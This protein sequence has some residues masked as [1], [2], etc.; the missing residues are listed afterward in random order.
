MKKYTCIVVDDESLARQLL[1]V[2]LA[3]I[4]NLELVASCADAVEARFV[5]QQHQPD[6]LFLDIQM[7]DLTGFELLKMLTKRPATI[8]TT[9][10]SE[11]ALEGFELDVLDYLLKPIEFE[12]FFKAVSKA[13][14]WIDRGQTL[15]AQTLVPPTL[16]P[17]E[18]NQKADYFFVKSD[19]KIVKV[20]FADILYIEALQ[21]YVRIHT[22]TERIVT[23]ISMS[24]LDKMLETDQFYRIHRSFI[25]NL[26][27][28]EHIEGHQVRI[29]KANLPVSKGQWEA[30]L[31]KIRKKGLGW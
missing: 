21:K 23:L 31:E 1:A 5:L 30:F 8:L 28:I 25:I 20:I 18:A 24:Q 13:V 6:I 9:A 7:P 14:D 12:R 10:F 29:G 4:P 3:K 17:V 15:V 26:E 11:Y 27:K 2:H 16:A 19:Y 22:P